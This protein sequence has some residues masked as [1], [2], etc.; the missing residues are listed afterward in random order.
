VFQLAAGISGHELRDQPELLS[1]D[2]SYANDGPLELGAIDEADFRILKRTFSQFCAYIASKGID[3]Q[4][5]AAERN[6][7][8]VSNKTREGILQINDKS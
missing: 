4:P 3:R 7:L 8:R 5:A 1:T 6:S 2:D